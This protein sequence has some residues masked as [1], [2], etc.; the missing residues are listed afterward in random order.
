[1]KRL[2]ILTVV[3]NFLIVVGAGHGIGFLGFI[4]IVL[5]NYLKYDFS[6]SPFA[7][8]NQSLAAVGLF[9]LIG[10]IILLISLTVKIY[11]FLFW[12]KLLGLIFLW[13]SF[14]YLTHTILSSTLAGISFISG[15]PFFIC[16]ILLFLRVIREEYINRKEVRQI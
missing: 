7:N 13:T 4:E 2:T 6:F 8:Y 16:S 9:A 10:Q 11:R 14:Y 1:M 5:F 3:F 15:L 12:I